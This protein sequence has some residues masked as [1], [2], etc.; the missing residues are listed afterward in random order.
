MVK[1]LIVIGIPILVIVLSIPMV[2]GMIPP[3]RYYGLRVGKTYSSPELWYTGNR[4][5]GTYMLAGGIIAL[6][7][8]IV[9][10]RMDAS[11]GVTLVAVMAPI[12]IAVFASLLHVRVL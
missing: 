9:L 6:L 3:N 8:G 10:T 4:I 2:M 1:S 11:R 7:L 5:G 12:L